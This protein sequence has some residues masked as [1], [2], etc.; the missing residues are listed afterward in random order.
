MEYT[1][2]RSFKTCNG[3]Q[4][5]GIIS[6]VLFKI[7]YDELI[8]MLARI[9]HG[10][11]VS[12]IYVGVLSYADDLTLI[13][14]TRTAL[15]TMVNE[16]ERFSNEFDIQFNA[17]KSVGIIF[18]MSAEGCKPVSLCGN[19]IRWGDKVR[20]LGN[21][22]TNTLSDHD[23][24]QLKKGKFIGSVNWF[25]GHF[26]YKT[27]MKIYT[28][29]FNTYCTS[30]YGSNLWSFHGKAFNDVCISWNKCVRCVLNIPYMTHSGLL[31]PILGC[32][33]IKMQFIKRFCKY[34]DS[35]YKSDNQIVKCFS[36]WA[37]MSARSPI[38]SNLAMLR[39]R[40][41]FK[42]DVLLNGEHS[43]CR[44]YNSNNL[45]NIEDS[46]TSEIVRELLCVRNNESYIYGMPDEDVKLI[47]YYL[48][49]H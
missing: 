11:R 10:C 46:T 12:N 45:G 48:C 16:C 14:P 47:M 15:Q 29:L 36:R 13:A 40:Y 33:H 34:F 1:L 39:H 24:V 6:P 25:I 49:C 21:V 44:Q 23:D 37:C 43:L 18:G 3:V 32:P 30:F 8:K 31:S 2:E 42:L 17:D 26:Q 7:Y 28:N 9:P 22:V 5:G 38:G 19:E 27:P 20:H 41:K 35:M 4:Q